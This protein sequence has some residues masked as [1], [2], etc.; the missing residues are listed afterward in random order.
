MKILLIILLSI[1]PLISFTQN[2][3]TTYLDQDHHEI[4][5]FEDER[6]FVL[7]QMIY[8]PDSLLF[9]YVKHT[10]KFLN[11]RF[12]CVDEEGNLLRLTYYQIKETNPSIMHLSFG[13]DPD[14]EDAI[15]RQWLPASS[16]HDFL[17]IYDYQYHA[18]VLVGLKNK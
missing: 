17:S 16:I 7:K 9:K 5:K 12:L 11:K 14:S 18:H 13:N 15:D 3:A 8:D 10:H 2:W 1:L 6:T 4:F